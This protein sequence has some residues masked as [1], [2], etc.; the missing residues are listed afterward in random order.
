MSISPG[1]WPPYS[2]CPYILVSE[3]SLPDY[4]DEDD[5]DDDDDDD[6]TAMKT[7]SSVPRTDARTACGLAQCYRASVEH[8]TYCCG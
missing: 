1:R 8:F 5:D 2:N 4:E 7:K 6:A 3:A